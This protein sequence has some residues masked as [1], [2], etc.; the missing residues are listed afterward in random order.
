MRWVLRRDHSK[1][2]VRLID[3]TGH[4]GSEPVVLFFRMGSPA[5]GET[6]SYAKLLSGRPVEAPG[7]LFLARQHDHGDAI[8]VSSGLTTAGLSGLGV[9]PAFT[10]VKSEPAS[11]ANAVCVLEY[12]HDAR[13]AG[14]L[15]DIRR[16]QVIDGFLAAIYDRLCGAAWAR[17]EAA[18]RSNPLSRPVLDD[19]QRSVASH[20]GF[21]AVLRRDFEKMDDPSSAR[22]WYAD[23]AARYG[24]CD[25]R[26]LC[27]FALRL[28][29]QPHRLPGVFGSELEGLLSHALNEPALIRGARLLALLYANREPGASFERLPRWQW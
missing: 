11:L 7:G 16:Q 19:L 25:R 17:T 24:I 8:I 14:F 13:L 5:S 29:S 18:L 9:A 27:D 4:E 10:D 23:L 21:A 12:W 26:P 1:I 22:A 15:P 6:C 28:A 3:D 20:G 2:V